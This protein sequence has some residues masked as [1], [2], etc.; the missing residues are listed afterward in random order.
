MLYIVKEI[1]VK[2]HNEVITSHLSEWHWKMMN[3]GKDVERSPSC[4]ANGDVNWVQPV[5]NNVSFLKT[6]NTTTT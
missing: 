3:V 4:T 1:Q 5:K 6:K 2:N